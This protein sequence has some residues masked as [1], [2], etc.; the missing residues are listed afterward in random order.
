MSHQREVDS[1]RRQINGLSG[2]L[3]AVAFAYEPRRFGRNRPGY[4]YGGSGQGNS[5]ILTK[6]I[7]GITDDSNLGEYLRGAAASNA[8]VER[9]PGFAQRGI[10]EQLVVGAV[11]TRA[12]VETRPARGGPLARPAVYKDQVKPLTLEALRGGSEEPVK[13]FS[14]QSLTRNT[15]LNGTHMALHRPG[16]IGQVVV[17]GPHDAI[18]SVFNAVARPAREGNPEIGREFA[19]IVLGDIL[20]FPFDDPAAPALPQYGQWP[21]QTQLQITTIPESGDP[22]S[23]VIV[24]VRNDRVR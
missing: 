7:R 19:R 12:R 22:N 20:Q 13:A 1:L 24:P 17:L 11:N 8:V 18:A 2:H 10:Y 15:P 3:S 6:D 21:A 5:T 23:G 4:T 14:Y 16:N 9:A